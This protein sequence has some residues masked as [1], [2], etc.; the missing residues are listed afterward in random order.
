MSYTQECGS[1]SQDRKPETSGTEVFNPALDGL[2]NTRI[3]IEEIGE[4]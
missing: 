4:H 1:L 3:K 2:G